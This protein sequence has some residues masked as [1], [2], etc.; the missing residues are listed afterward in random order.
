MQFLFQSHQDFDEEL[1]SANPNW[2]SS[3]YLCMDIDYYPAN[4]NNNQPPNPNMFDGQDF[5][6][7]RWQFDV[8]QGGVQVG[9]LL[10]EFHDG[11]ITVI[12]DAYVDRW[13]FFEDF[14][15]LTLVQDDFRLVPV[16]GDPSPPQWFQAISGSTQQV[17]VTTFQVREGA[18]FDPQSQQASCGYGANTQVNQGG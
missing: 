2:E 1:T 7:P 9:S 6:L 14:S 12:G 11:G 18:D 15:F 13:A 10:R 5:P 17:A 16:Q 3:T 4:P 8:M